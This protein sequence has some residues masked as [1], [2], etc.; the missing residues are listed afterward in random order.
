M[1]VDVSL[2]IDALHSKI[3][4]DVFANAGTGSI[5]MIDC[6][7]RNMAGAGLQLLM[8]GH[9]SPP[10]AVAGVAGLFTV[11]NLTL[12][13]VAQCVPAHF[14]PSAVKRRTNAERAT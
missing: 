12:T 6:E 3:P 2:T 9:G 14:H 13:D 7:V 11:R 1:N 5:A 8:G 4:I 10:R